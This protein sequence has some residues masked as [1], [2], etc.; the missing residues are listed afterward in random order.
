MPH[1]LPILGSEIPATPRK[2]KTAYGLGDL[3]ALPIWDK[4]GDRV[5]F[6]GWGV[7]LAV[8]W[9]ADCPVGKRAVSFY[10]FNRVYPKPPLL[11][12]VSDLRPT[13]AISILADMDR[14]VHWGRWPRVGALPGFQMRDWPAPPMLN[15]TRVCFSVDENRWDTRNIPRKPYVGDD[16]DLLFPYLLG[17]GTG[18]SLEAV[19]AHAI[20][21]QTRIHYIHVTEEAMAAWRRVLGELVRDG[22]IKSA[23]F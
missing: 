19:L 21:Y 12:E 10:G 6:Y 9:T 4:P 17:L 22:H 3:F 15:E 1:K 7:C 5:H 14:P 13:D 20:L 23:T 18:G 8:R 11:D 2:K 16:E